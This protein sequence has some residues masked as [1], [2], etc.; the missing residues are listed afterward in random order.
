MNNYNFIV[1]FGCAY[2]LS[3]NKKFVN[4]ALLIL[5]EIIPGFLT[6]LLYP[7]I[8]YK[9]PYLYRII[10]LYIIQILSSV[11]LMINPENLFFLFSGIILVSI[12]SYLGESSLLSL[13][14]FYDKKELRFWS[15]GTGFA[16]LMGTG[17]FLIFNLWLTERVIFAINLFLYLLGMS[18]GL[19]LIDFQNKIKQNQQIS[20]VN[21]DT[22]ESVS[23]VQ[24]DD[25]D[26]RNE[27]NLVQKEGK[28]SILK[29]N[30]KFFIEIYP[31]I[32]A[33]FFA[34]LFAFGYIPSLV[35]NNLNYQITQF[36]TRTSLFL[37]RTVG[38][39]IH[40]E[41]VG[42]FGLI[43]LYNIALL[44]LF[45]ITII[46]QVSIHFLIVN[47]LFLPGYFINGLS[48]PMVYQYIYITYTDEKEW[49]MGAVGQYT[50][51]LTILGC[52]IGYPLQLTWRK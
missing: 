2:A 26:S 44:V 47:L 25:F 3:E 50:S 31:I 35:E 19:Y 46:T 51:F 23:Q 8:L 24:L 13:S 32:L 42:L 52:A 48:Y 11:F 39:Y 30:F 40:V 21:E 7:Q 6:Q 16:G 29:R 28:Y 22:T 18:V 12:N 17:L 27:E 43:H 41:R 9:I 38:N 37:G 15:I 33:Y 10:T 36:I 45:T 1:I 14:S 20:E 34:Y 4:P 49:Y 5:A